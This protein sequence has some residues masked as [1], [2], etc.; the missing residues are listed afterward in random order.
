MKYRIFASLSEDSLAGYIWSNDI[1]IESNVY[2]VIENPHNKS[3]IKCFK[4]TI[5]DNFTR[6]YNDSGRCN[7]SDKEQSIIIN[8]YFRKKL[9]IITQ[10]EYELI[11]RKA[12]IFD[13]LFLL[14]LSHPDPNVQFA[15]RAT[16]LSMILGLISFILSILPFYKKGSNEKEHFYYDSSSNSS[17]INSPKAD[18][19]DPKTFVIY[20][21]KLSKNKDYLE[22][23]N[24]LSKKLKDRGRD[25]KNR[26][27]NI[28]SKDLM[29][30][31]AMYNDKVE[32]LN[33]YY[34]PEQ[35]VIRIN[36]TNLIHVTIENGEFRINE[37]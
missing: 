24:I 22:W 25:Y 10:N 14:H 20:L 21:L 4:R 1:S 3:R 5:D 27:F 34:V 26:H 13:K 23:G 31:F 37:Q 28:W 33:I 8:E 18:L 7:L 9:G 32:N 6:R 36:E 15:N 2:I 17:S 30:F 35:N 29:T 19:T 11:I 16:I 12:N